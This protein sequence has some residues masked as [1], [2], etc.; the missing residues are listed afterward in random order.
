MTETI[1]VPEETAAPPP[2]S[3]NRNFHVLWL[4]QTGTELTNQVFVIVYPLLTLWTLGS[5]ALAG[6]VGSVLV[7]AQLL[8]GLPAGVFADRWNRKYIMLVCTAVRTVGYAS[9]AVAL[10]FDSLT[11]PHLLVAAAI[12]GAALAALFPAEEAALPQVVTE[13]QLP[14]ALAMNNAR[15]SIGQLLGNTFGGIL[16]GLA[17]ALPFL[18]NTGLGLLSFALL[19]LLRLPARPAPDL[20]TPADTDTD[21]GT[22][23]EPSPAQGQFWQEMMEGLRFIRRQPFIMVTSL[24]AVVLNLVFATALLIVI[25]RAEQQGVSAAMIGVMVA[26][27]GVG[28]LLG[29]LAAAP[30]HRALTPYLS[31][32]G[33]VWLSMLLMPLLALFT[34]PLVSGLLL[35]TGA[36]FAPL[37]NT[38]IMTHQLLLT[39]DE[40][41][42][43]LGGA[44]GMLDGIS[45]AIGPALGGLLFEF[46]GARS[47]LFICAGL[48]LVPALIAAF[49]PAL[50]HFRGTEADDDPQTSEVP[51]ETTAEKEPA[52]DRP[53]ADRD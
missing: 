49:S 29:A 8:A 39:P 52:G 5:P 6:V 18:L 31:I 27:L 51:Q 40:M 48:A 20:A 38:T 2:L 22:E 10:H 34:E 3:R 13:D 46:G 24:C 25:I 17:V 36:F 32:T 26:M 37:A 30:L 50:R 44:M 12:E 21:S 11:L 23:D 47:G 43:R 4:A 16:I 45:G 1:K 15:V 28:G 33:V 7:G 41:R 42:G 9:V 19:L 53:S 35:A 14:T